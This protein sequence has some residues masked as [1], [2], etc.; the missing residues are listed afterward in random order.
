MGDTGGVWAPSRR[1][2]T[3]GIVASIT[4]SATELLAVATALPAVAD[5]LGRT[6]YGVAISSFAVASVLGVLLG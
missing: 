6:G 2:L 5:D 3:A 1:A 4:L